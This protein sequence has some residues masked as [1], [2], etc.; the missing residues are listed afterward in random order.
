MAWHL[1]CHRCSVLLLPLSKS[2]SKI[3]AHW[4][5]R[6]CVSSLAPYM[7]HLIA[8]EILLETAP[9]NSISNCSIKY[10]P[11]TY[12]FLS[13]FF[14]CLFRATRA[15]YGASQARGWI[16]AISAGLHHSHS[17]ARSLTRWVRPG[18][19]PASSW[20]LVRLVST[21]LMGAPSVL[22]SE[23]LSQP[24]FAAPFL[25]FGEVNKESWGNL[26]LINCK[27]PT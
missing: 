13:F 20:I 9:W 2:P 26:S 10:L 17:N 23:S 15:A 12:F 3:W 27:K 24:C 19:N 8:Q 11:T 16:G 14:F 5:C 6:P 7:P 4:L 18:I 25:F 21:E 22:Y 1:G